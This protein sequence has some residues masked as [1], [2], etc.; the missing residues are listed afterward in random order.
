MPRVQKAASYAAEPFRTDLV[1]W[2]EAG[3]S[4]GQAAREH[5][6]HTA[7]PQVTGSGAGVHGQ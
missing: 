6:S 4:A 7:G 5:R 3:L 2:A 1:R